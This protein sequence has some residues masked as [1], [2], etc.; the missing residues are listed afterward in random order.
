[1]L[2]RSPIPPDYLR[3]VYST[4]RSILNNTSF[5][6]QR[7]VR[8]EDP[9]SPLLLIMSLDEAVSNCHDP[10]LIFHTPGGELDYLA[11]FDDVVLFA[12][13]RGALVIRLERLQAELHEIG[14]SINFAKTFCTHILADDRRKTTMLDSRPTPVSSTLSSSSSISST[15]NV[16][17]I[18]YKWKGKLHTTAVRDASK[19]LQDVSH[20]SLKPQQRVE[21]LP[22]HLI[23]R[24]IHQLTLGVVHKRT[25]RFIDFTVKASLRKWL[26]L[27]L[28]PR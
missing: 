20:A 6:P 8:Q 14:L 26:R 16:L 27:H 19:M 7:G 2:W 28:Y 11:Y 13:S 3:N 9:L 24:L 12:E 1:M 4:D 10:K 23:P 21:I 18:A 22:S 25:L 17:G 15:W 5:H